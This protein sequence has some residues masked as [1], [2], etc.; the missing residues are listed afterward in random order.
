MRPQQQLAA[1]IGALTVLLAL[2]PL[3]NG[4]EVSTAQHH[5][6]HVPLIA[7]GLIAG[8]LA[9]DP[10]RTRSSQFAPLVL[11]IAVIAPILAM[12]LMWPSEYAFLDRHPGG[13]AIEHL[14]LVALAFVT[15]YTGQWYA[16]GIGWAMGA[17]L[18]LMALLAPFGFGVSPG[19]AAIAALPTAAPSKTAGSAATAHGSAVYAQSCAGCHGASGQGGVGPSL[20]NERTRKD[21]AQT[22]DWI[23]NPA[24]PMPKLYPSVLSEK[25]ARDVGAFV[26]SL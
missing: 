5:L 18:F 26:Q 15:A 16:A 25:D 9:W 7:G 22:I 19:P 13:H 24:P 20:K 6:M 14:G 17:A 21:L 11:L 10:A 8:V 12:F 4:E 23:K 2:V 3:V 1:A